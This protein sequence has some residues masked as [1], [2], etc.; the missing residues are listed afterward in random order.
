MYNSLLQ[1]ISSSEKNIRSRRVL[2]ESDG[3]PEFSLKHVFFYSIRMKTSKEIE[4]TSG[5]LREK[6][7]RVAVEKKKVE[8]ESTYHHEKVMKKGARGAT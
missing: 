3:R 8:K 4:S 5:I 1:K 6:E 7:K 2:S